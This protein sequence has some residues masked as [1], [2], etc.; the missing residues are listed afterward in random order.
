METPTPA[1]V[2]QAVG[3]ALNWKL[4]LTVLIIAIL[5]TWIMSKI[6]KQ[7]VVLL[8]ENGEEVAQG[9]VRRTPAWKF[10]KNAA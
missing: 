1:N 4:L 5:V 10:Q 6:M 9:E 2:T 8:D 7:T 3:K